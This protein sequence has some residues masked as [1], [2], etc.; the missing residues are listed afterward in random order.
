MKK[1]SAIVLRRAISDSMSVSMTQQ[2]T[3]REAS[4]QCQWGRSQ[5]HRQRLDVMLVHCCP[6]AVAHG[7]DLKIMGCPLCDGESSTLT[8][9]ARLRLFVQMRVM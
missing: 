8:L 9:T 2:Q 7:R 5:A 4:S 3:R 1:L 6:T